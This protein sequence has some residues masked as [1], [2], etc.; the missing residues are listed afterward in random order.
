M[1]KQQ[2]RIAI[3]N[4]DKC[5]PSKCDLECRHNCPKNQQDVECIVVEKKDPIAKIIESN[6]IGCGICATNDNN[7]VANKSSS[8]KK[9]RFGAIQIVQVPSELYENIVH[10]YG[11][12]EF[13]LYKL[14][15]PKTG[16]VMALIGKNGIGKSTIIKILSGEIKPNFEQYGEFNTNIKMKKL[17]NIKDIELKSILQKFRGT[18]LQTYF[19]QLYQNKLIVHTKPQFIEKFIQDNITHSDMTVSE[20]IYAYTDKLDK[21]EEVMKLLELD[22]ITDSKVQYL[23]GGELQRLSCALVALKNGN[24]YIFDEFANFLDIRQRQK[25]AKLISSLTDEKTYVIVIEHDLAILEWISNYS[26]I[27]YGHSGA[28]GI[29]SLP[30]TTSQAINMF[31]EGYIAPENMRFRQEPYH[32]KNINDIDDEEKKITTNNT[33][34]N[35]PYEAT[36]IQLEKF[37]LQIESGSYPDR[38]SITCLLG[39]NGAGKTT[40]V[41][42]LVTTFNDSKQFISYKPQ[43]L[44]TELFKL[45][46]FQNTTVYEM[47][48]NS[49]PASMNSALFISDVVK[50]LEADKLYE[51][52]IKNLSGGELQIISVIYCLGQAAD[53]Y[54]LDEPESQLDIEKRVAMCKVIKRFVLHNQKVAF[55]VV[56]DILMCVSFG[57]EMNSQL[58]VFEEQTNIKN[59]R[60]KSIASTALKFKEGM[61]KFL[62]QMNITFNSS[63]KYNRPKINKL[64]GQKDREQKLS[65]QYYI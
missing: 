2:S 8:S 37:E 54:V 38:C 60:K 17:K 30:Y 29:S 24:V 36:T 41:K 14:P 26:C 16:Q 48:Y 33:I 62:K 32:L 49:I 47:L 55:I 61:N 7:N 51:K 42:H 46:N 23:S 3:I 20:F 10:R 45:K 64:N 50:P 15:I 25:V 22:K 28:Y 44:T 4:P 52:T 12:N 39:P 63:N 1:S 5:K 56:H 57:L 65:N 18:E 19:Q 31:F 9:C 53:I 40:F 27:L 58:I 6:C 34:K 35:A 11:E 59:E 43:I 21:R 13:R